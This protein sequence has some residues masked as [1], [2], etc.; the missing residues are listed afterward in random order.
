MN[1]DSLTYKLYSKIL[2]NIPAPQPLRY[3]AEIEKPSKAD[4]NTGSEIFGEWEK[5]SSSNITQALDTNGCL[6]S[7]FLRQPSIRQTVH[8]NQRSV[9]V[10]I[11]YYLSRTIF[12]S[13]LLSSV[14]ESLYGQPYLIQ[15]SFPC[16][17]SSGLQS[18]SYLHLVYENW[19]INLVDSEQ[20]I[21]FVDFGGGYGNMA[22]FLV[23]LNDSIEVSIVDLPEMLRMQSLYHL[24]TI[25]SRAAIDRIGYYKS[26]YT[27]YQKLA[28]DAT[29]RHLH[30]NATFSLNEAPIAARNCVEDTLLKKADTFFVAYSPE[31][32][33]ID[34]DEWIKMLKSKLNTSY[35]LLDGILPGYKT[36][37][38]LTGK[39][40]DAQ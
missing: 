3:A 22:R 31:F 37:R 8:P 11:G 20:N 14:S 21:H 12:G 4:P 35:H 23:L 32:Y 26:D 18:L 2:Q 17:S 33:G 9:G 16:F 27:N 5:L 30:F 25:P 39:R 15:P 6:R 10:R 36:S 13:H 34:N 40:K 38:F 19:G 28:S 1:K 7:D 29:K 24:N